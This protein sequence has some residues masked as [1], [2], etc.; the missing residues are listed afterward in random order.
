MFKVPEKYRVI[1][2]AMRSTKNDGN[3][4]LFFVRKP[5]QLTPLQVI[6]SDG[7]GW[8]HVSISLPNRTPTWSEMSLIK[9]MFWDST[10]LVIQ[11]HPTESEYINNHPYCL[12]LWRK[13]DTNDFCET[14]PRILVGFK[15]NKKLS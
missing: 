2:G 6:A 9:N 4:G 10:D 14:P 5:A 11:I 13:I 7:S 15:I 8:E 1:T 3:N 12:H